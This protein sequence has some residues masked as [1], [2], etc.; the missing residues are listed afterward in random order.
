MITR[1]ADDHLLKMTMAGKTEKHV[2]SASA[3]IPAR[4]ERVYSLLANYRDGHAR[5][6]PRQF[7]ELVVE[8]GGIG[9]GT[10]IR[11]QMTLLGKKQ[12]YHATVSEP[13]PGRVL[14]ET[15]SDPDGTITTFTV[16][17]GNAPAASK[18]TISTEF[19]VQSGIAGS[20]EKMF[21]TLILRPIFRKELENLARVATGPFGF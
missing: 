1:I 10:V 14:V 6:L 21:A 18:V 4:R 8:Q 16:D 20:L 19:P 9:S 15:Y 11:F 2:V 13:E 3:I 7:S 17:A 5:I 12:N